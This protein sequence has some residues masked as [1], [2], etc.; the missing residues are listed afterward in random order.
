M[1]LA[2]ISP[3]PVPR[4][5]LIWG[6]EGIAR[7]LGLS[8]R[9]AFHKLKSGEV[10]GAKKIAGNYVLDPQAFRDAFRDSK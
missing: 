7:Y 5:H 3:P 4:S 9:A 6:A 10:P 8:T 2:E 1:S